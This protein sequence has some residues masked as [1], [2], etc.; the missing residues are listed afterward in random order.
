MQ[1]LGDILLE[2]KHWAIETADGVK[3]ATALLPYKQPEESLQV[4]LRDSSPT[5]AL[6]EL[7]SAVQEANFEGEIE[8]Y[9]YHAKSNF[10]VCDAWVERLKGCK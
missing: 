1:V 7:I 9:A 6:Q 5:Q 4:T 2:E 8:L 10:V 3:S